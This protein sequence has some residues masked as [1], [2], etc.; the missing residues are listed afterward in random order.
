[1]SIYKPEKSPFYHYDFQRD[2]RR[3]HGSTGTANR[4]E[5]AEVE[6]AEK[7]KAASVLKAEQ[8]RLGAPLTIDLAAG[9]YWIEVGQHHAAPKT[10]WTNL[11]R[12]VDYFG[13]SKLLL[14]ITDDDVAALV[15]WRR[16][17]RVKGRSSGPPVA[18]ATVNRSTT[19]P[20]Q[21]IFNRAKTV[22]KAHL[23]DEPN[24]RSHLLK[25]PTERVREVRHDEEAALE[26]AIRADYQPLIR[27]ARLAGLRLSE[28]LLRK[29]EVDLAGGR[30]N[31][32]GK[33][34]KRISH[35]ITSGMRA[36]LMTAMA[37]PTEY[38]FAYRAARAKKG[39]GGHLRGEM[40]P[41]TPSGLKSLWRRSRQGD[42]PVVPKDLRFHDLRHDFATKLLRKTGNLKLVQKALHHSKIETTTKYAHVLDDEVL[43]GME[44]VE[45][46]RKNPGKARGRGFKPLRL[47]S[48]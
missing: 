18:L 25:E 42:G 47:R 28:C 26:S 14:H 2:G 35:P 38:V 46:S 29:D 11:E 21:K 1:M 15:A 6:R 39:D 24:W 31:T 37:N 13:K 27:F 32:V 4:R 34:G 40:M 43:A 45:E 48:K 23:P 9:R 33:G 12:L 36:I 19:E 16:G 17:Q 44:E 30:I 8:N 20:L 3:F 5:A 22:W 10:T 7:A 41:I